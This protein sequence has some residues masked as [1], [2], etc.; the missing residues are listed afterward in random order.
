MIPAYK[1]WLD[2][3]VIG[4][5][6]PGLIAIWMDRQGVIETAAT[7]VTSSIIVRLFLILIFGKEIIK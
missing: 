6:I 5:I 4:Y 2:L 1:E 7:L 3:T